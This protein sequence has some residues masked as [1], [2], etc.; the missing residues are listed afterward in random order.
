MEGKKDPVP[1]QVSQPQPI[2]GFEKGPLSNAQVGNDD[3]PKSTNPEIEV[4]KSPRRPRPWS[5]QGITAVLSPSPIFDE[6]KSSKDDINVS[7]TPVTPRRPNNPSRSLSLQMPPRDVSSTSTANLAKRVPL[8]PKLDLSHSYASA[9]SVLPRRSRGLDFSRACTSLHHS[10]LAEQS[11]PDSSPIVGGRNGMMIPSRKSTYNP[12][13]TP[14]VPDSPGNM[15]HSLWLSMANSDK[16]GISSSLGSASMME[17][18]S[19]TS[20]SDDDMMVNDEEE[21]ED[22]I[23]MTPQVLGSGIGAMNPPSPTILASPGGDGF[24]GYSPI[25]AKLMSFQRPR[26]KRKRERKSSSSASGQS[27]I[28]G[29]GPV[30]PLPLLRSTES[31][32]NG[33]DFYR[34]PVKKE[35]DSRR[36]SLSLGTCDL[37]LSDGDQ[38]ETGERGQ[39]VSNEQGA[40][41][42]QATPVDERRNV[43]RRAVTMRGNLLPKSKNF[44]RIRAALLEEVAPVDTE[45]KREAEVIRQVR[46]SDADGDLS[47]HP[48]QPA[49]TSSSPSLQAATAGPTDSLEDIPEDVTMDSDISASRRSSSSTF[50]QQAIR[51]SA[52]LGFWHNFD[53]RIRTPPPTFPRE[54]SSGISD[55]T[56]METPCSS[57]QAIVAQQGGSKV[58]GLA[59]SHSSTPQ[60][61]AESSQN[62]RK[63][64]K[65]MRDD[66]FDPSFF[67]RRAVSPGMSL[68]N[69]PILP[70][71]PLQRDG[72]WWGMQSKHTRETPGSQTVV[73]ERIGSGGSSSSGN[74]A[75]AAAKRVGFQGM[76]DTNDGLMNM[77]IE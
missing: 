52:G 72:G 13:N 39:T 28:H 60:V 47:I 37:H 42:A 45:V 5:T 75:T 33:G 32:T 24:S 15:N 6:S 69:S 68:Q 61:T 20:S 44:N 1:L 4:S 7:P 43:I 70:Q 25:A 8:S 77:S 64:N 55:D 27:N 3:S 74:G 38:S 48:S 12:S 23:H 16:M 56:N 73:G 51:N 30:S 11:S 26:V 41:A 62:I 18:D 67:K 40:N 46:E 57:L 10:T 59:E 2:E 9:A 50:T 14:I 21:E 53:E 71:S 29:S 49:T 34:D 54:N 31:S 19:G 63:G 65:R 58:N 76:S 36:E 22:T 17:F 35:L 66:D